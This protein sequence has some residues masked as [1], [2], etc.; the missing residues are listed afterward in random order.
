MPDETHLMASIRARWGV[1]LAAAVHPSSLPEA[2]LA[3][4]VANE[5]GGHMEATRFEPGVFTRLVNVAAGRQVAFSAPGIRRPLTLADLLAY[6][7]PGELQPLQR[8]AEYDG[9]PFAPAPPGAPARG[10][11]WGLKRLSDLST[12][13]GLTQLMGWH[14]VEMAGYA[15]WRWTVTDLQTSAAANLRAAVALFTYFASRYQ[16]DLATEPAFLLHCWNTGSPDTATFDP[17]YVG[18]GLARMAAY[19]S[20]S[21]AAAPPSTG[22]AVPPAAPP[23]E[24]GHG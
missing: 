10:L 12:S 11:Q 1:E 23:A 14:L 9:P 19:K 16:I 24:S 21:A 13:W 7:S 20:L 15:G 18:N 17:G 3:A 8:I 2:F 6:A 4:V 22:G 5:S